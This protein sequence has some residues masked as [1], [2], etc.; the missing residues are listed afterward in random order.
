MESTSFK[1][2]VM[3]STVILSWDFIE[4]KRT[5]QITLEMVGKWLLMLVFLMRMFIENLLFDIRTD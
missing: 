3:E 2:T 4:S 1:K 5:F